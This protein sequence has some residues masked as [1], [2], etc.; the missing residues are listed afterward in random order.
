[1]CEHEN[2]AATVDVNRIIDKHAFI[3][4]IRIKC[5]DCGEPFTFP[6]LPVEVRTSWNEQELRVPLKPSSQSHFNS[7][8]G[9]SV[10]DIQRSQ[11]AECRKV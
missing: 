7:F 8:A 2:F 5:A 9:Y 11:E 1:M 10:L 4:D 6:N 3:A